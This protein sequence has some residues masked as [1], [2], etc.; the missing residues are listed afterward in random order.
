MDIRNRKSKTESGFTL[1]EIMVSTVITMMIIGSI[2][3]AF[4]SSLDVY[5]RDET[6]IIMLQRCR[7]TLDRIAQD[8]GNIFFISDDEELELMT[9]D[10]SDSETAMDEDMIS[11]VAIVDPRLEDYY[12]ALEENSEILLDED[13]ENPL[14]SDLSRI[15]YYVGPSPED[16]TVISLMRI[17]TSNLDI[18]EFEEMLEELLSPSPSEEVQEGLQS[19]IL[20]DHVAGLNVR[21]FDG[22]DWL[23]EWD[24]EEQEGI[25][26]GVEVTLSVTDAETQ[27]KTLTQAVVVYLPMSEP[28]SEEE[29]LQMGGMGAQR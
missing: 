21:Y 1:I 7:V 4:R 12:T 10:L 20:V 23:D 15:V 13:E 24:A 9:E 27:D 26:S 5:Q 14:P 16:D 2:Y 3:A 28:A 29:G 18:E 19:S 25:P 22:D 6:R 11:F 8:I 17:E